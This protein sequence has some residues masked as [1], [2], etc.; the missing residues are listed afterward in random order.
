MSLNEI[1]DDYHK[2]K[3]RL[4]SLHR[5]FNDTDDDDAYALTTSKTTSKSASNR[6][7]SGIPMKDL[8]P[9]QMHNRDRDQMERSLVSLQQLCKTTK[10]VCIVLYCTA[11]IIF[12]YMHRVYI[13]MTFGTDT[14]LQSILYHIIFAYRQIHIHMYA[15]YYI[16]YTVH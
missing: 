10:Q 11:H 14:F 15:M 2:L 12:Y 9:A 1:R 16:I 6:P 3:P 7:S 8:T 13:R 4:V 5:T